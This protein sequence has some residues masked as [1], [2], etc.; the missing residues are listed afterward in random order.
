MWAIAALTDLSVPF[1]ARKRLSGAPF[2]ASHI[3]ERF[4]GFVIIALGETVVATGAAAREHELSALRLAALAAA[5]AVCCGLW[6]VYFAFSA[7]AIHHA[8]ES[9]DVRIEIIRPVLSYGHLVLI[10]GIIS[11]AAAIGTAVQDPGEPLHTDVA[12]LLF[13]GTCVYLGAFAFNRWRMFHTVATPRL[14]AA[15][16]CLA[17]IGLAPHMAGVVSVALLATLLVLLNVVEHRVIPRTLYRPT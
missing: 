12:A 15:A 8:I 16:V 14:V 7:P 9:A 5:F 1:L 2:E 17:L 4:G 11:V 10:A 3:A 6:W 13:A